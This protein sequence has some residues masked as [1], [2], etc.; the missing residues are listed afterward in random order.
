MKI[1]TTHAVSQTEGSAFDV[2]RTQ[3]NLDLEIDG[4]YALLKKTSWNFN[5]EKYN[6]KMLL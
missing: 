3:A 6:F 2:F 5:L 1:L 4:N